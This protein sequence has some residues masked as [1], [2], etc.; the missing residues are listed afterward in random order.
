MTYEIPDSAYPK[1]IICGEPV[2]PSPRVLY[3]V[4][5]FR[6]ERT[7][8]GQNH[9]IAREDT[10]RMVC[11]VCAEKVQRGD[12][13]ALAKWHGDPEVQGSLI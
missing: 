11:A 2:R 10:G 12:Y 4:R 6:R 5:G 9:V 7:A 13:A 3:E 8:G 1:C